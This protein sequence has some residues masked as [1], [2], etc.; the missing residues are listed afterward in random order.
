MYDSH[1]PENSVW[2]ALE[3]VYPQIAMA[4]FGLLILFL[5]DTAIFFFTIFE[6]ASWGMA[7]V[8]QESVPSKG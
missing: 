1:A 6:I 2:S 8:V 4:I 5:D 7:P 3:G